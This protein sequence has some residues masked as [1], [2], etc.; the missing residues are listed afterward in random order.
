MRF[1]IRSDLARVEQLI[2]EEFAGRVV[3]LTTGDSR[4]PGIREFVLEQ[5]PAFPFEM[6]ELKMRLKALKVP[7]KG[8]HQYSFPPPSDE[9]NLR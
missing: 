2:R 3:R 6:E 8:P 4:R 9:L 7:G 1:Q 5:T